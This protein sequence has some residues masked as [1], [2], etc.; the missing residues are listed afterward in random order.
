MTDLIVATPHAAPRKAERLAYLD[1][2]KTLLIAGIIA[3]HAV[4]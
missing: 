3:S 1:N 2:L 4:M